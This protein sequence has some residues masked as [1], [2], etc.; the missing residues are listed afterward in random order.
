MLTERKLVVCVQLHT[1]V[2]WLQS[3]STLDAVLEACDVLLVVLA[4]TAK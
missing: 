2:D 4:L 3:V 1:C